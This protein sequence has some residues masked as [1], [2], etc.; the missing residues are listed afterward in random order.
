MVGATGV[1]LAVPGRVGLGKGCLSGA[2][3]APAL[4][5]MHGVSHAST[6]EQ[7][8]PAH[9]RRCRPPPRR[10][11]GPHRPAEGGKAVPGYL[12][13][14][15]GHPQ[16]VG[17]I[18]NLNLEAI[19]K[20]KPDLILGSQLRAADKYKQLSAIAPT[21]FSI[22]PGFTWKENYLLNAAAPSPVRPE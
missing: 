2:G 21:V 16:N 10:R 22:R 20:L 14:A 5:T 19:A 4:P 9:R 17:T 7:R 1:R 6:P 11:P 18:N 8:C 3:S 15:A 13:K 12:E